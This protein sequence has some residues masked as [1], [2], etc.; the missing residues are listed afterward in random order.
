MGARKAQQGVRD[1]EGSAGCS[2]EAPLLI[3]LRL[4]IVAGVMGLGNILF[5][6]EEKLKI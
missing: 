3:F 4:L 5:F 6:K 2:H 1:K